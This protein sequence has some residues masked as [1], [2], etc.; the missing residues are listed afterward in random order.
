VIVMKQ[1]P[2]DEVTNSSF[3]PPHHKLAAWL[4]GG[5]APHR[6]TGEG[7]AIPRVGVGRKWKRKEGRGRG[8]SGV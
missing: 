3:L 6:P 2:V 7:K 1:L 5:L 8:V 4:S